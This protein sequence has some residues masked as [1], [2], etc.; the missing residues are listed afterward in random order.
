MSVDN[1]GSFE[2]QLTDLTTTYL[3]HLQEC[4]EQT[5]DLLRRYADEEPV[6]QIAD[7][8]SDLESDCDRTNREISA[9]ISGSS[10]ETLGIRLT[11]VH[12][13]SGQIIGLYQ[14]LDEVANLVEQFSEE[15]VAI[16]PPRSTVC[17]DGLQEMAACCVTAM[18]ALVAAV[19]DY[20][21]ALC[22]PTCSLSISDSVTEIRSIES[23]GDRIRNQILTSAF[24]D[25]P[26]STALVYLELATCLDS[27]IDTMED[28]TD[29]MLLLTGNQD[30]I[31]IEPDAD[32]VRQ[33]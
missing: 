25:G 19:D 18:D 17:L 11:R 33:Q 29:Q 31:D 1:C 30:W 12:L 32:L 27:A 22:E 28:V 24:Q 21:R 9:L 23:D 15:L 20:V 6:D 14:L 13:H 2:R 7:H 8:V 10:V 3:D 4:V 16:R 26:S 5:S